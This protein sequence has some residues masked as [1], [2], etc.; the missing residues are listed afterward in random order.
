MEA[1]GQSR[2]GYVKPSPGL[3]RGRIISFNL[4]RYREPGLTSKIVTWPTEIFRGK[5]WDLCLCAR[6]ACTNL[7]VL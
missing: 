2:A 5:T 3:I 1:V 4:S 7:E 6:R